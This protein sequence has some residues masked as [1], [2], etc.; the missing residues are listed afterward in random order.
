MV[1]IILIQVVSNWKQIQILVVC[2]TLTSILFLNYGTIKNNNVKPFMI[3]RFCGLGAEEWKD[4]PNDTAVSDF[5]M[6]TE[7]SHF[8]YII[9][10]LLIAFKD[11]KLNNIIIKIEFIIQ[12]LVI[13]LQFML[14]LDLDLFSVMEAD[15]NLLVNSFYYFINTQLFIFLFRSCFSWMG[16][17]NTMEAFISFL[18]SP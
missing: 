11:F 8:R 7:S 10:S 16:Y 12:I 13:L 5:L 9:L 18:L 17:S 6:N 14:H 15:W 2:N 3:I 1:V 4:L